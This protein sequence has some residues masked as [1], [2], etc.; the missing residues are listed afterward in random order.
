VTLD[1][2]AHV[3]GLV[4]TKVNSLPSIHSW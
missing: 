4:R 1:H 2:P 3:A